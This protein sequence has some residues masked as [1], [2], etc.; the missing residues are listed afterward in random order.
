MSRR[1]RYGTGGIPRKHKYSARR[2]VYAGESYAS[3][4]EAR[5]AQ[6][7]DLL[8]RVGEIHGWRRGTPVVLVDGPKRADRVTYIPDFIVTGKDGR[9]H[10]I[11]VKGVVTPLFRVKALLWRERGPDMPLVVINSK[12]QEIARF[13][14]EAEGRAGSD[15]VSES[16]ARVDPCEAVGSSR[17]EVRG[18][19]GV[20]A[21]NPRS[22]V[23]G[24]RNSRPG[25]SS[26]S[27][28]KP[29]HRRYA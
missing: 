2:A 3:R 6:Q 28:A 10:A 1:R 27:R 7:L 26:A 24:N 20:D 18:Q 11:D 13:A 9:R 17:A 21:R 12:N 29:R 15:L 23:S 22:T 25:D 4:A 14:R 16:R 19:R 5:Y 8:R